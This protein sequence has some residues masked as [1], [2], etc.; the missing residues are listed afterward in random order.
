[1]WGH[2]SYSLLVKGFIGDV[3]SAGDLSSLVN[4]DVL[5]KDGRRFKRSVEAFQA[6][7]VKDLKLLPI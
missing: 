7:T 5:V 3:I 2:K 4:K 6:K 1:M